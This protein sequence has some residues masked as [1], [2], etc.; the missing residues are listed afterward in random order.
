MRTLDP[1]ERNVT[2]TE[3]RPLIPARYNYD[4]FRHKPVWAV[5]KIPSGQGFHETRTARTSDFG[6]L[7]QAKATA[8]E[9]NR[10]RGPGEYYFK[11]YRLADPLPAA[12]PSADPGSHSD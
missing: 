5:Y 8:D 3:G 7:A 10:S 9:L 1:L 2:D 4:V 6:D 11:V 12:L